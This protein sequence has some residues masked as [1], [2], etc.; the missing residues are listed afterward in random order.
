MVWNFFINILLFQYLFHSFFAM[1]FLSTVFF[2]FLDLAEVLHVFWDTID[3]ISLFAVEDA[4]A[5]I[6]AQDSKFTG[7][8]DI[9]ASIF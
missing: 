9:T 8:I 5:E 2:E 4:Q 1:N 7:L 3:L 6:E